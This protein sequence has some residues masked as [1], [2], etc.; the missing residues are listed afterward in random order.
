MTAPVIVA[1]LAG[2]YLVGGIPFGYLLGRWHG[3]NLF[4]VGS[5]NIGATN[6]G[7]VLGRRAGVVCFALDFLKGAG[8][9]A[10]AGWLG[11]SDAVRVGAA[12]LAFA[13]HLFPVY[14]GF[15]GGKGVATGAG[16]IAVLV[17]GP[18]AVAVAAWV[19]VVLAFRYVSLASLAAIVGLSA[20]RL[21]T[22]PDPFG[23]D[24]AIVT[25]YCLL[26]SLLVAVKH[27]ANVRRMWA[28][29]ESQLGDRPMRRPALKG[30]HLLAVG[31]WFGGAAFFNFGTA[32][33]IFDSFKRVVADA[34]SDRTAHV[35]IVPAGATPETKAALANALAGA[36]VGPVFPRYFAM[37]AA[38][39][40]VAVVTALAWWNAQPNRRAHRLRVIVLGLGLALVA[41]GWPVSEHVS[42]LRPV[43]FDP[44][45]GVAAAARDAFGAWHFVSL[46]LSLTTVLLSGVGLFLGGVTDERDAVTR[47]I[48]LL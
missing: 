6:V 47:P 43:R 28:G 31:L 12:A 27:R 16:T 8:P 26:G 35:P 39:G 10:V 29:T 7:R 15:R 5:G 17:P 14:L 34:P 23:P 25:G 19:V 11:G 1:V 44:D 42:T 33:P 37:Q 2:S 45:P 41:V 40:L 36:A 38:C 3:V 18:T 20:A 24:S 32:L 9:V 22:V 13:G 30:V 4:T 21:L 48:A 46:G